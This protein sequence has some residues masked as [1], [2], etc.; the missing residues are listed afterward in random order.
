MASSR[1][2]EAAWLGDK[3][4]A[5]GEQMAQVREDLNVALDQARVQRER[6]RDARELQHAIDLSIQESQEHQGLTPQGPVIS[7]ATLNLCSDLRVIKF[8]EF[9]GLECAPVCAVCQEEMEPGDEIR[10]LQCRHEY[11]SDC[12]EK[13][14]CTRRAACPLD[15]NPVGSM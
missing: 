15:G 8:G 2:A 5:M 12:I 9:D 10:T 7:S 6:R 13:W 4:G 1:Q 11:H 3:F 14:V